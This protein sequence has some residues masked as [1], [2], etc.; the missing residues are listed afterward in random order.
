MRAVDPSAGTMLA[1]P[2]PR[3]QLGEDALHD[4]SR[5]VVRYIDS[6]FLWGSKGVEP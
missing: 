3:L 4:P 2:F 1:P 5:N 6:I